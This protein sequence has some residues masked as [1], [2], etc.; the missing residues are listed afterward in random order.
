LY[1]IEII[2]GFGFGRVG[3]LVSVVSECGRVTG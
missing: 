1:C 3:E 2:I